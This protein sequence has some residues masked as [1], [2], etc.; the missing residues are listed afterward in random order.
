MSVRTNAYHAVLGSMKGHRVDKR[1]I[2]AANAVDALV[3]AG[4]IPSEH[5]ELLA[6]LRPTVSEPE[7]IEP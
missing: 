4:I 2:V 6:T 3:E 1:W 7:R 5:D